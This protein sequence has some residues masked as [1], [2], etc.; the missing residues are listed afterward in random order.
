[1][2]ALVSALALVVALAAPL[3]ALAAPAPT[4]TP[5]PLGTL[6]PLGSTPPPSVLPEIGRVRSTTPACSAMRE[7][8]I[9]SFAAAREA[10]VVFAQ[11]SRRLPQYTDLVNDK[12][13]EGT[14]Y[15]D[16]V[17]AR[18]DTDAT[19]L[20]QKAQVLSRALGDP[21]LSTESKDPQV[22][23]EREQL[24]QLYETQMARATL[25]SQFV[26]REQVKYAKSGG[27]GD[28]SALSGRNLDMRPTPTPIPGQTAPPGMPVLTGISMSDKNAINDWSTGISMAVRSSENK[29]AKTFLLIAQKCRG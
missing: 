12:M 16:A 5:F 10:D 23:A 25:L 28:N 17:L 13:A 20:L 6:V 21:R 7:L 3:A 4:P 24:E 19:A 26:L 22:E 11:T 2:Q 8:V 18:L 14:A 9:P 29:A 15:R 27:V 1:M